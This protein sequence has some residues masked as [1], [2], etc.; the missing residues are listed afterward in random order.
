MDWS[1]LG[2]L[3]RNLLNMHLFIWEQ[4][5]TEPGSFADMF[6]YHETLQ[7]S[8]AEERM[9]AILE[10]MSDLCFYSIQDILGLCAQMFCMDNRFILIGPFAHR[11]LDDEHVRRILLDHKLPASYFPSLRLYRSGFP[12]ADA[13]Y[14]RG[15][16]LACLRS[17]G[18]SGG[19]FSYQVIRSEGHYVKPTE[20]QYEKNL[21]YSTVYQRY[22]LENRFLRSI[23]NGEPDRVSQAFHQLLFDWKKESRRYVRAT[24]E[25]PSIGFSTIRALA[26]KAAERG[27]A[28]VIEID[29]I[30][31]RAVQKMKKAASMESQYDLPNEMTMELTEAVCRAQLRYGNVSAPVRR[32]LEYINLNFSQSIKTNT[33]ANLVMLSADY[34]A[35]LFHQEVGM[36]ISE[37]IASLRCDEAALLLKESNWSVQ[38]ISGYVGYQDNNYFVK[39][40]KAH[41]SFTPTAFRAHSVR[42][43]TASA[44]E[45]K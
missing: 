34:A 10:N 19:D 36:R 16:I 5:H 30:T 4:K 14:V 27:G 35:R 2:S 43:G 20:K 25:D 28:S 33:L 15:V 18:Y 26:R 3:L 22:D 7:P 44:E 21:D 24:Y 41:Y 8:F 11:N 42:T 23:E 6:C 17:M 37:Y 9:R 40:F 32:M 13:S 29:E 38:E 12:L 31:Q 1:L 39:V 45:N